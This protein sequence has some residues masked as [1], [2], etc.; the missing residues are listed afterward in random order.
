MEPDLAG[1]IW[2]FI[3]LIIFI[4]AFFMA[5]LHFFSAVVLALIIA[6]LAIAVICPLSSFDLTGKNKCNTLMYGFIIFLTVVFT[7]LYVLIM[8]INDRRP[9]EGKC[10]NCATY[11]SI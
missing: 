5:R 7:L 6:T 11:Q 3:V 1:F 9:L 8:A 2:V 10:H 4:A